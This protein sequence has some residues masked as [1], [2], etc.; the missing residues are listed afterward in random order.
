MF[1]CHMTLNEVT[2]NNLPLATRAP[3]Y[4]EDKSNVSLLEAGI[5]W[6][7]SLV[8]QFTISIHFGENDSKF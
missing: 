5:N 3:E 8:S 6:E 1:S 2:H 4:G 7:Y